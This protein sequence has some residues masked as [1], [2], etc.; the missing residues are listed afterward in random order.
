MFRGIQPEF[1]WNRAV[2]SRAAAELKKGFVIINMVYRYAVPAGGFGKELVKHVQPLRVAPADKDAPLFREAD[3]VTPF[4]LHGGKH[5]RR[6][7]GQ[8]NKYRVRRLNIGGGPP[9]GGA[10]T[11]RCSAGLSRAEPGRIETD[12]RGVTRQKAPQFLRKPGQRRSPCLFI[13]GKTGGQFRPPGNISHSNARRDAA[14]KRQQGAFPRA[15]PVNQKGAAL[16]AEAGFELAPEGGLQKR[17]RAVANGKA[18]ASA[19]H[20]RE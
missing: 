9:E 7:R 3:V 18:G 8:I 6:R 17:I 4:G 15:V 16:P 5:V 14:G 13:S 20:H 2:V 19:L 12:K 11:G 10:D 1:R